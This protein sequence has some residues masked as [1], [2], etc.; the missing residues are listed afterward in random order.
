MIDLHVVNGD[1]VT[2]IDCAECDKEVVCRAFDDADGTTWEPPDV[3]P[4]CGKKPITE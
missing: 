3:C 2:L 1:I 4:H